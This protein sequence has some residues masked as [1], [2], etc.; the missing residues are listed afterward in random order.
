MAENYLY[1]QT[2]ASRLKCSERTVYRL[3]QEGKLIAIRIGGR[4]IRIPESE[5]KK[6]LKQQMVCPDDD[7]AA[8]R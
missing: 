3:V 5:F 8:C 6:F 2:V 7:V 1:V 4:A